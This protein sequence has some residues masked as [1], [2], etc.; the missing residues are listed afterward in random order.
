MEERSIYTCP[1]QIARKLTWN[2]T[3]FGEV[4]I[5]TCPEGTNGVARW[6]CV[7]T[8]R[9]EK[10]Q[11]G[12]EAQWYRAT[13]DL[14]ECR[15][16]WL[17][18]LERR[19]QN[20][21]MML[22][23]SSDLSQ[24]TNNSRE[25]YGGDMLITTKILKNMAQ[26]MAEDIKTYQDPRQREVSVAEL[27]QGAVTTGSNLLDKA[28]SASWKDLSY[29]EQML[30]ATSLLQGLEENAFLLANTLTVQKNIIHERTNLRK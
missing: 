21:E 14:S 11:I 19:V 28:K 3:Q 30:V 18:I 5:Q 22:S 7:K 29:Q 24:V 8:N 10:L 2:A 13:P 17:S 25:L 15:S 9:T 12:T 20:G 27:L 16:V 23:V 6:M 26:R 1:R 4:A